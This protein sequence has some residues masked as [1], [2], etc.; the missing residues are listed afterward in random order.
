MWRVPRK[1]DGFVCRNEA[2]VFVWL[3]GDVVEEKAF[4]NF[5]GAVDKKLSGSR[6]DQ[7]TIANRGISLGQ[8]Q[9][10]ENKK[11]PDT[12]LCLF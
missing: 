10:K 12:Q 6:P 4:R 9:P 3:V 7:Q 2:I 11:I 5:P 8:I 1:S